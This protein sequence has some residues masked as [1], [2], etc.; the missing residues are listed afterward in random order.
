[1]SSAISVPSLTSIREMLA[2]V[3]TDVLGVAVSPG[4]DFF[5][6]GGDSIAAVQVMVPISQL[7]G[8][9]VPP[10][11]IY[12]HTTLEQLAVEIERLLHDSRRQ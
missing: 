10:T 1:M 3:W 2:N 5:A 6:L 7:V 12:A 8:T 4:D 9:D 11:L